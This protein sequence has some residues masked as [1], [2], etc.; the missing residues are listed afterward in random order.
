MANLTNKQIAMIKAIADAI[1]AAVKEAGPTGAPG[2]V[3]YAALMAQG[4]T[5][6]QFEHL[7]AALVATG[8]I[9]KDGDCYHAA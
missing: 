6:V 1:V 8:K 2:G 9:R 4:C 7:M 5:L 3:I